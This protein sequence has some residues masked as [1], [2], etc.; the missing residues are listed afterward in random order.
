[1]TTPAK[2]VEVKTR[3][4]R[5]LRQRFAKVAARRGR[6]V[7]RELELAMIEHCRQAEL[8]LEL[9]GRRQAALERI[10]GV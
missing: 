3:T 9:E 2:R 1:M 8:E 6:S 7:T 10:A 4:T 5:Q